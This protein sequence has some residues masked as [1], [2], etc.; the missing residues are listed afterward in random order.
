V[1]SASVEKPDA[2]RPHVEL[3]AV[4]KR[5]GGVQA[6]R[7]VDLAIAQGTI[8]GL[9]GENGAGKSTLGKIVAGVHRPDGGELWIDGRRV[10][11][12]SPRNA[13]G[14]GVTMIAQEPTLVPHRSVLENIFLGIERGRWGLVRRRSLRRRYAQLVDEVELELP[15]NVLARNLRIADR[16]KAEILRAVARRARLIVMDEPTSALTADEAERLFEVVRRLRDR[17]TTIVY[18][19]HFLDEV[20]ALV[21]DVTVLR[22]GRLIRTA[23][24]TAETA[25]R[26]VSAMLGRSLDVA[27]PDKT[28]PPSDAPVVFRV[29]DLC[30]GGVIENISF[31]VRAGEIVGLAG[32]IGSGRS[33]VARG[34]VGAD[35]RDAGELEVDGTPVKI[36]TP[37]D[38][39]RA[40]VV[41]LPEDRKTQGL[42][43]LRSIGDNITLPHLPVLSRAGVITPRRE[44]RGAL[45][46]MRRVDVRAKGLG[47]KVLTLSGGNQQKVLFARWLFRPPRLFIAD[48][49]TRGV[50]VGAKRA[51]WEL[52]RDLAADG[53]AVLLISS[54]HE[55]VLGLA[56]R[57]LVMRGGK[58]VAELGPET[59]SEEAVLTAAFATQ[60]TEDEGAQA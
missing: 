28:Y 39:V 23:R 44:R 27:F 54:E 17:G 7:D 30:R 55:E 45:E 14:D 25:D 19:S 6:L 53:K 5:F 51:I 57:V 38:G 60:T 15:P 13:L 58:I 8:H 34:I 9:V 32:L 33:E 46:L 43:M 26:L 12:R 20:L 1:S 41:M 36:R 21:E 10:D 24:A 2:A 31:E 3:R 52:I 11:Y 4:S 37:R 18:V 35:R 48:E 42:L 16:Q 56:H 40:G 50:D 22:D 29:R 47:T 49:P 59:M